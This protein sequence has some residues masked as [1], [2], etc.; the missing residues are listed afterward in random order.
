LANE[1]FDRLA[2]TLIALAG[3]SGDDLKSLAMEA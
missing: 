2:V 1:I 3:G